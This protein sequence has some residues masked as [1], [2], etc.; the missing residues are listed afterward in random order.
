MV[1]KAGSPSDAIAPG[2]FLPIDLPRADGHETG[3]SSYRENI[4]SCNGTVFGIG[5]SLTN[6]PGN[7]IG[8]TK[9]GV[10]ALIALDPGAHWDSTR[11]SGKGGVAGGCM[12]AGSC[13][14]SPR[15]V[16]LPVFNVDEYAAGK[17]SGRQDIVIV[18]I[19]GFFI[20]RMQG[21]DVVGRLTHYPGMLGPGAT[22]GPGS[23]FDRTVILVR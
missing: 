6:E 19:L 11:N 15:M 13:T 18:N 22:V 7:M 21:N 20:E 5:S 4:A 1:L 14:L 12:A 9:Q 23:A 2:W 8:P 17:A 3:G 16:A 10:N